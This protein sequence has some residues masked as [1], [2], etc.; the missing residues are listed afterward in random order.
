MNELAAVELERDEAIHNFE[1][2]YAD[3]AQARY[4]LKQAR[5]DLA[6]ERKAFAA[7][8]ADLTRV[9][10]ERDAF[11]AQRDHART[12][13]DRAKAEGGVFLGERNQAWRDLAL[14]ESELAS[15]RQELQTLRARDND[16]QRTARL[17]LEALGIDPDA[18]QPLMAARAMRAELDELRDGRLWQVA[19]E[20][21]GAACA[22]CTQP[23]VRGQAFQPLADA[24]GYFAHAMCPDLKETP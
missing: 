10:A 6:D 15:A 9:E 1:E 23:I 24:K 7:S 20:S 2:T 19:A 8:Q 13:L 5:S 4:E 11:L 3:L 16:G 18:D 12:L 21:V 17:I 22:S 14:Q